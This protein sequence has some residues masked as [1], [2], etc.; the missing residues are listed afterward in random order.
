MLRTLFGPKV[1]LSEVV[2]ML[3]YRPETTG[4]ATATNASAELKAKRQKLLPKFLQAIRNTILFRVEGKTACSPQGDTLSFALPYPTT[5]KLVEIIPS[6]FSSNPIGGRTWERQT[7][8]KATVPPKEAWLFT[9]FR[10][11]DSYIIV[12]Q[13][14]A[15]SVIS[16]GLRDYADVEYQLTLPTDQQG[17][18]I[19][20]DIIKAIPE[21]LKAK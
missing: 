13:P 4:G 21:M 14:W 5:S 6:A 9:A 16:P 8:W 7:E 15:Q 11:G 3:L 2:E 10:H 1:Q 17:A 12:C 19:G 20:F 18:F